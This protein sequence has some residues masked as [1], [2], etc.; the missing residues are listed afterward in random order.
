M[1]KLIFPLPVA[2]SSFL[3][4]NGISV[5]FCYD[6][7]FGLRDTQHLLFESDSLLDGRNPREGGRRERPSQSSQLTL[8]TAPVCVWHPT[9]LHMIMVNKQD[10]HHSPP[11]YSH[12]LCLGGRG[13]AE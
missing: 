1:E 13:G 7:I 10:M 6:N 3:E 12:C 4:D 11:P 9:L 5:C 8:A 2:T